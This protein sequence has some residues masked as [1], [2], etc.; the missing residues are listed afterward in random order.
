[1]GYLVNPMHG[2]GPWSAKEDRFGVAPLLDQSI[3]Q[4]TLAWAL[5]EVHFWINLN[6]SA[7][8]GGLRFEKLV[9]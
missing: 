5:Q 8:S 7:L 9:S 2:S 4:P 3:S 1:M 6:G